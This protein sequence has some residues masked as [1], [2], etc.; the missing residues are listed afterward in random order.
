MLRQTYL[1]LILA[2]GCLQ[3]QTQIDLKSQTKGVDFQ[4]A[5]YTRPLKS[6]ATLPATCT[7]NE[8]LLL[9][10]APAGSNIYACLSTNTWVPEAGGSGAAVSV[11]NGGNAVGAEGTAN[12]V[13]GSGIVN[14]ITDLGNKINIQQSIDSAA[15][16]SKAAAQTGQALIC[17]SGGGSGTTYTCSMSPTLTAYTKGMVINWVADVTTGGSGA[18]LNVDLLGAVKVTEADGISNPTATDILGGRLYTIWY[19]GTV[20]RLPA[21]ATGGGGGSAA[22][23]NPNLVFATD[24]VGSS[25]DT[26]AL[27]A[28][29]PADLPA[30]ARTRGFHVIF[31]GSDLSV[32]GTVYVTMPYGCTASGY[33]LAA[34]PSGTATIKLWKIADGAT[35]PTAANSISTSGFSLSSGNR[36]HSNDVSDLATKAWAAFDTTAVT[37]TAVGG[38]PNH[39]NFMLECDQ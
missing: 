28:L 37:L 34:D 20:F 31:G 16:L 33:T 22:A 15:V 29:V 3:A 32:G 27:R 6:S 17:Q 36:I 18:T 2:A 5:P 24:P 4:S 9:S 8:L 10:S 12:F 26:A 25:V 21:A 19:D 30:A 38:S 14:S 1:N 7:P 35:L 39:V 23:G 11:Q 13:A